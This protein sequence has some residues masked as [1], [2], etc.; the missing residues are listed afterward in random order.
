M[1]VLFD[2]G[3]LLNKFITQEEYQEWI[4]DGETDEE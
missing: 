4:Q 3:V 2:N 1:G